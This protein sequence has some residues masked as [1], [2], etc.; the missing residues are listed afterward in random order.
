MKLY[1]QCI[2]DNGRDGKVNCNTHKQSDQVLGVSIDEEDEY[3]KN[4]N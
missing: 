4:N 2:D 3:K 1:I